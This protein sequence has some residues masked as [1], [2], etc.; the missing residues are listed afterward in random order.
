MNH[1]DHVCKDKIWR[2]QNTCIVNIQN[3]GKPKIVICFVSALMDWWALRLPNYDGGWPWKKE[4]SKTFWCELNFKVKEIQMFLSMIQVLQS[5]NAANVQH[6]RLDG[7]NVTNPRFLF[8]LSMWVQSLLCRPLLQCHSKNIFDFASRNHMQ[9]AAARLSQQLWL[10]LR[11]IQQQQ[12]QHCAA[13][14]KNWIYSLFFFC[15]YC[16]AG[17]LQQGKKGMIV[18]HGGQ[19]ESVAI[20]SNYVG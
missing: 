9:R 13:A 3:V 14:K 5:W 4:K 1:D 17:D 16:C 11:P 12:K 19:L 8:F 2:R 7:G 10:L 6:Y 20:A 18:F 15:L